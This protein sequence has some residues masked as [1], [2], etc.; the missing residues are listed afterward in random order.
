LCRKL[1]Y[2]L[3]DHLYKTHKLTTKEERRPYMVEAFKKYPDLRADLS[4]E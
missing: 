4:T 1:Y 2:K 3:T